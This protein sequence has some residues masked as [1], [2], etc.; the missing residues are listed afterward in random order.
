[1]YRFLKDSHG[2]GYKIIKP[3]VSAF[4]PHTYDLSLKAIQLANANGC[5]LGGF[6][7]HVI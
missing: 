6:T 3:N 4:L 2:H 7:V 1:M 5:L